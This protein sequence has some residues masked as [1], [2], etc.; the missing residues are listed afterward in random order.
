RAELCYRGVLH[1]SARLYGTAFNRKDRLDPDKPYA[2]IE[3]GGRPLPPWSGL[4]VGTVEKPGRAFYARGATDGERS[5]GSQVVPGRSAT[6]DPVDEKPAP[7]QPIK[8]YDSKERKGPYV[9]NTSITGKKGL[10]LHVTLHGSQ[11]NGGGAGEYGDYYLFFGT[12]D[13]G[14]RD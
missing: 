11:A 2:V 8:L 13:M 10:P 7:I 4:A 12:R 1:N 5:P 3:E 6:T 14:H 9:A